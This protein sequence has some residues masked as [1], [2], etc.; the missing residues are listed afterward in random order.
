[1][2]DQEG[3]GKYRVENQQPVQGQVIGDNNVVHQ[4]FDSASNSP[5]LAPPLRA[6]NVPYSCNPFFT[7]REAILA[8]IRDCFQTG[9][10]A[11][12]SQPQAMNGLGGIGKTQI[13]IEYAHR[14]RHD[15]QAV[16]WARADT[17]EALISGYVAIAH[18]LNLPHVLFEYM[19]SGNRVP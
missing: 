5:L 8:Q 6:W 3:A 16:L 17:R 14:Y 1:M 2:S 19:E 11:A 12:L 13:A 4:Y 7:G 9:H 15:Y 18:L 10:A